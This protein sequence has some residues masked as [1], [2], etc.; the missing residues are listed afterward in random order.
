MNISGGLVI[1][2]INVMTSDGWEGKPGLVERKDEVFISVWM[3]AII[4]VTD[5][6]TNVVAS[7]SVC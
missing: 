5:P 4:P 2:W 1:S 3:L 6:L 7:P